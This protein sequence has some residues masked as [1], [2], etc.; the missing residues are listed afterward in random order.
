MAEVGKLQFIVEVDSQTGITSIKKFNTAVEDSTKVVETEE[1][2]QTGSFDKVNKKAVITAAAVG[3]AAVKMAKEIISAT[4]EIENGRKT[5]VQA[6][7]ATGEALESLM[8]SAKNVYATADESFGEVSTALGE[9]NTRFGLVGE[10]LEDTTGKFLDFAEATNQDVKQAVVGVS[11]IMNQWG[12]DLEGMPLLLDKLTVAGQVSG[13]SI[14]ALSSNLTDNAGT[15]QAMGYSMDEAIAMMMSFEKQGI[16][17]SAVLMGMKQSFAQSAKAGTDARADWETLLDSITNA[18]DETVANSLAVDT[19]GN[20]IATTM[21]SALRNGKL[22]FDEFTGALENAEGALVATDEA[23]KTTA[24]RIEVLRHQLTLALSDI[25]AEAAP[26]IE[27]ILPTTV[28]LVNVIFDAIKPIIPVLSELVKNLL[29]PITELLKPIVDLITK[30]INILTPLLT[31]GLN[32]I[33]K[34]LSPIITVLTKI[35]EK[36]KVLISPIQKLIKWLTGASDATEDLTEETKDLDKELDKEKKAVDLSSKALQD[37]K[38]AL[39]DAKKGKDAY[40]DSTAKAG[41]QA[42]STT[43]AINKETEALKT[44]QKALNDAKTATDNAKNATTLYGQEIDTVTGKITEQD[45]KTKDLQTTTQT[46]ADKVKSVAGAVTSD[47]GSMTHA[48]ISSLTDSTATAQ[49]KIQALQNMTASAFGI[50]GDALYEIGQDLYEGQADW[51][52]LGKAAVRALAAIV[53]ALAEEMTARA[54][55]AAFSLNWA[56]AAVLGAG[57]AA[58]YIAAGMIEGWAN[59]LAVGS[60]YIPYDDYPARL[61]RGEMVLTRQEADR[62]RDMGGLY[63][64]ERQASVPLAVGGGGVGSVNVNNNLSAV[65]EVDG[66]QLGVAVLKNIDSA[67]QF[68]LR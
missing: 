10:A 52:R 62:F 16:D 58:A 22:N 47:I 39:N 55:L 7:G 64:I 4:G 30:V 5:I 23:G 41:K 8:T 49:D 27:E 61:H 68:V 46:Y 44:E 51:S 63:G 60:D 37:E 13:A 24:D 25:G 29:P 48:L 33:N 36:V 31:L 67:S 2:K 40:A 54:V 1:K 14:S 19:F 21:V 17:S 42:D 12:I 59:S 66:V 32:I 43:G 26:L 45:K 34:V 38:K 28:D 50:I 18:T 35:A 6:T 57:A 3:A 11:Q 53:R 9:I 20:R 65:I 15:L 56:G